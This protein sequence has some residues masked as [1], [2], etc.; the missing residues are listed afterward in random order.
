[1]VLEP[2]PAAAVPDEDAVAVDV[3]VLPPV[4]ARGRPRA[5]GRTAEIL[6]AAVEVFEEVGYANLRIQDIADRAGAG[7]ATIYRRW[8]T[9]Q[10]LV[11]DALQ[12]KA[13]TFDPA[14]CGDPAT[15]FGAIVHDFAAVCAGKRSEF[16][17]GLLT[18]MSSDPEFA[19]AFRCEMIAPLRERLREQLVQIVG[20]DCPQMDLLIDLVPGVVLF[21]AAVCGGEVDADALASEAV[22]LVLSCAQASGTRPA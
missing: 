20:P 18:A 2:D 10:A 12:H 1:M 11:A 14:V 21:R 8:P 15:D 19:D 22:S 17:S 9:K 7:L 5:E 13:A 6:V 3:E 16:L 4:P